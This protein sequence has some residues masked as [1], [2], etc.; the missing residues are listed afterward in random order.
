MAA[1][2]EQG[3]RQQAGPDIERDVLALAREQV[4][5]GWSAR[6]SAHGTSSHDTTDAAADPTPEQV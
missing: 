5:A 6:C 4:P 2:V 1:S 3:S